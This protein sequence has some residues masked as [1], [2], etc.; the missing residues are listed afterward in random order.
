MLFKSTTIL[1]TVAALAA[2][3]PLAAPQGLDFDVVDSLPPAPSISIPVDVAAQTIT[4]NEPQAIASAQALATVQPLTDVLD[5][6]VSVPVTSGIITSAAATAVLAKRQT[7]VS[8]VCVGGKA[9]PTGAGPVSTPD[10]PSAFQSNTA[11][12][13]AANNAATPPGYVQ[14]FVNQAGSTQAGQAYAYLGFTSISSYDPAVCAS[15]CNAMSGC[16]SFNICK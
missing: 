11:Y 6:V 2:A 3:K 1:L 4:V 15:R 7:T 9:Q 13:N 10:T 12:S 14:T 8:S 16:Q 5:G